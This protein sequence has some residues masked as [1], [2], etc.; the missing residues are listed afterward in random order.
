MRHARTTTTSLTSVRSAM[1]PDRQAGTFV[2]AAMI[3]GVVLSL[4]FGVGAYCATS[5][6]I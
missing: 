2:P 1:H 6:A 4:A 3:V 5:S